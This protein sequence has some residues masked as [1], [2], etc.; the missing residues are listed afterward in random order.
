MPQ[1]FR[2]AVVMTLSLSIITGLLYP[3]VVT[4]LGRALFRDQA[5]GSLVRVGDRVV[6]SALIG[7]HFEAAHYFHGRPSNAGAGYDAS[8]SSGTNLGPTSAKLDARVRAARDS[9]RERNP[10]ADDSALASLP[11]DA[12][13]SSAS[14]LDPH[15]T[16]AYARLQAPRVA[17]ARGA[18]VESILAI[19][20][21]RTEG[22]QLGILG[23][24]RVNVLLLNIALDCAFPLPSDSQQPELNR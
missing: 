20:H 5:D 2:A 7:Q 11:I 16:P 6:G 3:G 4:V 9:V 13:T 24:P 21:T 23:E 19:V 10:A 17:V 1:P 22:R 15:I 8:A 12:V 14:G 18:T